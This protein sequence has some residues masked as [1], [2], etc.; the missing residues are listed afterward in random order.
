MQ[1][2]N[3][4]TENKA[5]SRQVDE[6]KQQVDMLTAANGIIVEEDMHADLC[7]IINEHDAH[8]CSASSPQSFDYIFWKQQREVMSK[9]DA[10][11]M[12]WHPMMIK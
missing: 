4:L 3:L 8:I 2:S 6:L 12:C 9:S 7:R 1:L 10:R 11:Q 5:L